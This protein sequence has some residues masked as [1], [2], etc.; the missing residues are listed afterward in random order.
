MSQPVVMTSLGGNEMIRVASKPIGKPK[1]YHFNTGAPS[2]PKELNPKPKRMKTSRMT[3][4]NGK[5]YFSP[6]NCF[7]SMGS[8]KARLEVLRV[9][10]G[11]KRRSTTC[12]LFLKSIGEIKELVL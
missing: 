2:D 7:E 11:F 10:H 4:V 12:L 1:L 8:N 5:L 9:K 3:V 6:R